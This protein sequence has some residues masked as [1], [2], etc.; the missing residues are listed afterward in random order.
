M[1]QNVKFVFEI[2]T[3][4]LR[5]RIV[6]RLFWF[7]LSEDLKPIIRNSPEWKFFSSAILWLFYLFIR[8]T[9][10]TLFLQ[11]GFISILIQHIEK[12]V[13]VWQRI[14]KLAI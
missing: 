1:C 5:N 2:R 6:L 13:S 3:K 7:R 11:T 12:V 10:P 4:S 8:F 14:N 9:I